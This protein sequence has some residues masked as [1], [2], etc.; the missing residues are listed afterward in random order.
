LE[1]L[2]TSGVPQAVLEK[3]RLDDVVEWVAVPSGVQVFSIAVKGRQNLK[4]SDDVL[5]LN[6]WK[7]GIT[8]SAT[9]LVHL[10]VINRL[11]KR[12]G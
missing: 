8:V 9:Y 11:E 6:H 2:G 5:S 3:L 7:T 10:K 12:N 4:I 1:D